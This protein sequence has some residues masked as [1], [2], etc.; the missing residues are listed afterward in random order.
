MR[1][2]FGD[3]Q[4][5]R[6]R[7]A[8]TCFGLAA[9]L[10]D[11]GGD[12]AQIVPMEAWRKALIGVSRLLRSGGGAVPRR[13]WSFLLARAARFRGRPPRVLPRSRRNWL[14]LSDAVNPAPAGCERVYA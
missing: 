9:V 8:D 11:N 12:A 14:L 6:S 10:N 5:A 4:V 1:R 7:A 3:E 2:E 13:A